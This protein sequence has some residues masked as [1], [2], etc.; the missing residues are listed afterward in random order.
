MEIKSGS[1]PNFESRSLTWFAQLWK[2]NNYPMVMSSFTYSINLLY[3]YEVLDVF[4]GSTAIVKK[5]MPNT[6][7]GYLGHQTTHHIVLT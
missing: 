3:L 6:N 2:K 7:Q 1:F 5:G 4:A